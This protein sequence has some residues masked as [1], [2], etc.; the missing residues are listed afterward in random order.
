MNDEASSL[1]LEFMTDFKRRAAYYL[2]SV[3]AHAFDFTKSIY[4]EAEE[5]KH[6]Q[7]KPIHCRLKGE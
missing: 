7:P 2:V 6:L 5:V 4:P 1:K 3:C